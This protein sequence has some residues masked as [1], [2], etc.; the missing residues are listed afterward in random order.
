MAVGGFVTTQTAA[1]MLALG[2][3]TIGQDNARITESSCIFLDDIIKEG[4]HVQVVR[5][6]VT[7]RC[8]PSTRTAIP[9]DQHH[10]NTIPTQPLTP[11]TQPA[12][13]RTHTHTHTPRLGLLVWRL[14]FVPWAAVLESAG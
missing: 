10:T 9:S 3:Q 4:A 8:H 6:R 13:A 11:N 1:A 2:L 7:R 5:N 12:R 14:V